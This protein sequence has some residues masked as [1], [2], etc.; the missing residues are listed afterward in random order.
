MHV[1]IPCNSH[2][3][4]SLGSSTHSKSW[5]MQSVY[6]GLL[7]A[8]EFIS[9]NHGNNHSQRLS[10]DNM[11]FVD[12]NHLGHLSSSASSATFLI[13]RIRSRGPRRICSRHVPP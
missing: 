8:I 4:S 12:Y 2:L 10:Y 6:F 9:R 11:S 7:V 1:R 5:S 3:N 13:P